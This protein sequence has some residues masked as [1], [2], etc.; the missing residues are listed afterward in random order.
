MST[1]ITNHEYVGRAVTELARGLQPV[2][3]DALAP[4]LL[5]GMPWTTLLERR[6]EAGGRSGGVY[7]ETDLQVILRT[8]TESLGA[9]GR[10]FEAL[11]GRA[12]TRLAGELREVRNDWAHNVAFD[13]ADAY[14]AVDSAQRLLTICGATASADA[15]STLRRDLQ[16]RMATTTPSATPTPAA[17]TPDRPASLTLAPPP[18][19]PPR[20]PTPP[21]V[22][23]SMPPAPAPAATT[24]A[25]PASTPPTP[26]PALTPPTPAPAPAAPAS[27]PP[28]RASSPVTVSIS[29]APVISYAMAHNGLTV[30]SEVTLTS[31][32]TTARGARLTVGIES[33]AGPIGAPTEYFVDLVAGSETLLPQLDIKVD[34]AVMLGIEEARP[35]RV[36]VAVVHD[37]LELGRGTV[38]VLLLAA[39]QWLARPTLMSLE[40]LAAHVQPNHPAL[41]SLVAEAADELARQTG[42]GALVGYQQGPE[43][44]DA[45]VDAIMTAMRARSIRYSVPPA[46]WSDDGQK[47]R[48]PHEVLVGRLGTCL[49]TT[50]TLAAA[51][52]RVGI[53]PMLVVVEGHAFLA[54]WREETSLAS[55]ATTSAFALPNLVRTDYARVIETTMLTEDHA[56]VGLHDIRRLPLEQHLSGDLDRVVGITD[57]HQ[58]RTSRVYPLPARVTSEDGAVVVVDYQAVHSRPAAYV[59]E[60]RTDDDGQTDAAPVPPRVQRWKNSLLDLSLRNRL[61]NFADRAR[62]PLHVAEEGLAEFED[63]LNGGKAFELLPS[64]ALPAV[65][66]QRG[67]RWGRD[68]SSDDRADLF[69]TKHQLYTDAST[70]AYPRLLRALAYKAKTV[71]DETGANNL[72]ISIGSLV[73]KVK[74]K[75]VRSPLILVPVT[76]RAKGKSGGYQVVLDDAGASTPNYCLLEKLRAEHGLRIPALADPA[77]DASGIDIQRVLTETRLAILESGIEANV[78]PTVDVAILQFAKFRLWKDLDD[79]WEALAGNDLVRHLI[80]SPTEPFVD[81]STAAAQGVS[82]PARTDLDALLATLPVSA[83]SSQAAA[84]AAATAGRTFVLE[85]PPG[86]GKSQTITNLLAKAITE[87]KK[88]LF[89]AEKRAALEV[90]QR[91]LAGVGLGPFTLDLH[92]KGSKPA[93]LREHLRTSLAQR[94]SADSEGLARAT[95]SMDSA[96]R[97]LARYTG[98]VHEVNTT[99]HSLYSAHVAELVHAEAAFELTVPEH[100]AATASADDLHAVRTALRELA[101]HAGRARPAARHAW[102]FVDVT[103]SDTVD[104]ASL[105]ASVAELDDALDAASADEATAAVLETASTVAELRTLVGTLNGGGVS[106]SV[107]KEARTANW[108]T[109]TQRLLTELEG[110]TPAFGDVLTVVEPDILALDL[111]RIAHEATVAHSSGFFGRKKRRRAVAASFAHVTRPGVTVD[112]KSLPSSTARFVA[113]RDAVRSLA[114][115]ID[116]VPGL[117]VWSGWNP[118]RKS[119]RSHVGAQVSWLR[120]LSSVT[121]PETGDASGRAFRT[122]L[123]SLTAERQ[124][125]APE[126]A[127]RVT[128]LADATEALRSAPGTTPEAWASW[129]G[130]A[131]FFVSWK[132]TRTGRDPLQPAGVS[133]TNWIRWRRAVAPLRTHGL[134]EAYNTV[135]TGALPADEAR[136]A[137]ER[138]FATAS[139]HERARS[140]GLDEFDAL[141]QERAIDRY[142]D[143]ARDIRDEL[144]QSIPA[145]LL[146]RRGFDHQTAKGRAGKFVAEVNKMRGRMSVRDIMTTYGDLVAEITPCVLVSPDSVARFFPAKADLFDIVVFDEASQVRVADAVG[147]MGRATSVVVVGDSKQMPP[148]SFAEATVDD[149]DTEAQIEDVLARDEESI[150]AECKQARIES[151]WLSWHYRSQDESLIAFSNRNYYEDRLTSFPAPAH[152][153]VDDGVGGHGITLRRVDGRFLRSGP[154]KTLRTNQVEADAIVAEI[155][156][157]FAVDPAGTPSL[158]VVTFNAQQRTLIESMLRDTGDERIV[159]ALDASTDGLFVK[160]L[161]NV[162]GDER[163]TILFSTAFSAN[164]KGVLPLNFGPL[165]NFGGERRL[166]V[167]ITRARRQVI[168]FSS[169]DPGDLRAE[170]TTSRGIRDLRAYLEL[171]QR[172]AENVLSAARTTTRSDLHREDLAEALRGRGLEVTTDV[173]LSDFKVDLAVSAAGHPGAPTTAVLLDG[174]S[175]AQRGTVADRDALPVEVLGGLMKWPAVERVW[176]PE[177]LADR[178]GVLDRLVAAVPGPAGR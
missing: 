171:A 39:N 65:E 73:W 20:L 174:P 130:D 8:M 4:H 136:D 10:P 63:Y 141:G 82:E 156:H 178:E 77:G 153:S 143:S 154:A 151:R 92:D 78:E 67:V 93:P 29:C 157:R 95:D 75:T 120:W 68:L 32:T 159:D 132:A 25:V 139:A 177:W 86:T 48:T 2:V 42:S 121:D 99:G 97:R 74:D 164:D 113:L 91:R 148:T 101:D 11:L 59:P 46:S 162:Q 53:R 19:T 110:L 128:R 160:N 127:T 79:N 43:R 47:V 117:G 106:R 104:E 52:E 137:F 165:T 72:Y 116:A 66:V 17:T 161:E 24:P 125:A 115:Q 28:A 94:A 176:L 89:V 13:D 35:A 51:L 23:A 26:T 163:D 3:A 103:E 27:T 122:A 109:E 62:F 146:G 50:V 33:A 83:D 90:V 81:A 36:V 131:P 69:H 80:E 158:G 22:P 166:N 129:S 142:T 49:D 71:L 45:T 14:R 169:F 114:A 54:Y 100:F 16:V 168:L 140:T 170:E 173:G 64:D 60:L 147:A 144:P 40:M 84:V 119:D 76:L 56:G 138:G 1:S 149:D 175:W 30:I 145:Q 15:L 126:S 9:L 61:I 98:Q 7:T 6:D 124:G 112:L 34:P 105:L 172:G 133:L 37:D 88:V 55:P 44:V 41:E 85:G 57:V 108:R 111:D 12:G 96:R 118:V 58:A 102:S 87:G 107:L 5:A 123:E 152:G 155:R 21:A 31:P 150:L 167:A 38:D 18:Q 135:L 70:E 134:L